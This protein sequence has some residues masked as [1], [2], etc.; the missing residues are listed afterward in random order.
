MAKLVGPLFSQRAKGPLSKA[1]TYFEQA[2]VAQVTS[3]TRPHIYRSDKQKEQTDK[4]KDGQEAWKDL[5]VEAKALW[6]EE[7]KQWNKNNPGAT[8]RGGRCLFISRWLESH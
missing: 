8:S 5:S 4:F 6:E 2:G 3:I 7:A 1:I